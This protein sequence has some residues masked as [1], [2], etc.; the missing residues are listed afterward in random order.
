MTRRNICIPRIVLPDRT[1]ALKPKIGEFPTDVTRMEIAPDRSAVAVGRPGGSILVFD[2]TTGRERFTVDRPK[3]NSSAFGFSHNGQH[4]AFVAAEPSGEHIVRVVSAAEG[5]SYQRLTVRSGKLANAGA[6]TY[7]PD[8][9]RLAVSSTE[10][11]ASNRSRSRIHRWQLAD[12]D[13]EPRALDALEW[14]DGTIEAMR[15]TVFGTEVLAASRN[16]GTAAV[17]KWDT[18]EFGA[19]LEEKAPLALLAAGQR[20]NFVAE[21]GESPQLWSWRRGQDRWAS[22]N[23]R[24]LG[25]IRS[26]SL[27]IGP[28]DELVAIGTQGRG[29]GTWEHRTAVWL[30]RQSSYQAMLLGH[31]DTVLDVTFADDGKSILSASKD[32]T[33]RFWKLP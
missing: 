18:K 28:D 25:P 24:P 2:A 30:W 22:A 10:T 26:A 16:R 20:M 12:G 14:Q 3:T 29:N 5:T 23:S 19:L 33:L 11:F 32:G 17:W 21:A 31:T 27:A 6:L 13:P 1:V 4:L 8:G 15:F 7:S 9:Q